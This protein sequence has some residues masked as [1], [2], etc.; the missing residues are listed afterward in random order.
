MGSLGLDR[1]SL[2]LIRP[3]SGEDRKV[4]ICAWDS[5]RSP[6]CRHNF[7]INQHIDDI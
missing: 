2:R 3:P 1:L 7:E 6:G 4:D 5:G